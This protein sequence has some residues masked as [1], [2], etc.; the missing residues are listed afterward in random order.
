MNILKRLL[1]IPLVFLLFHTNSLFAQCNP[2]VTPPE[3]ECFSD[4]TISI[5]AFGDADVPLFELLVSVLD[6]CDGGD[7]QLG[8]SLDGAPVVYASSIPYDCDD[9]GVYSVEVFAVDAA[10]NESS[11]TMTLEIRDLVQP[12]AVCDDQV[13]IALNPDGIYELHSSDIDEGS[14]DYCSGETMEK[15][16]S[17]GNLGPAETLTLDCG[18]LGEHQVVLT[19]RDGEGNENV[20]WTQLTVSDPL[21]ACQSLLISGH[22]FFDADQD[23]SLDAGETGTG[24]WDVEL[25]NVNNNLTYSVA[26]DANG[27]YEFPLAIGPDAG[28]TQFVVRLPDVPGML[29]PCGTDYSF[30]VANGTGAITVDVPVTLNDQCPLMQVDIATDRLRFCDEGILYVNF[31]N[32]STEMIEDVYLE[33]TLDDALTYTGSN[34]PLSGSSNGVYT[35]NIGNLSSGVC[36]LMQ[37]YVDV[38]CE[39]PVFQTICVGAEIYP[40]VFCGE[41]DP[42]WSGASI[43]AEAECDGDQV[44]FRLINDGTGNMADQLNFRIVEDVVMYMQDTF[45]LPS[46]EEKL[47]QMAANGS[48][49]RIEAEQE[50]GHPGSYEP[51]AWVEG[52][53]GINTNGIINLFPINNTNSF[54]SKFCIETSASYDPNDKQGFPRGISEQGLIEP[55]QSL[56]YM[57]RFQNTGNDTAFQVVLVDTLAET[58]DWGS[59]RPGVSSHRYHFEATNEG[60]VKFIF[61]PIALPDSNVNEAA[62]HGF[63]RFHID[64]KPGLPL[65]TVIENRAGIYFDSNPVIITNR[66]KHTLG[67]D[68]I[69]T[70]NNNPMLPNLQ[71][72]VA[73]NPFTHVVY[74]NLG[75]LTVQQG[76]LQVF[77]ANGKKI[78]ALDFSGS[79]FELSGQGLAPGI[80]LF[81]LQADGQWLS[82]GKL[83]VK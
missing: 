69:V 74:F 25:T 56:D 35:F 2:D 48:T 64:Q 71:V 54:Q 19:V 27:Y 73:P 60:I 59:I 26:S 24:N 32:F 4:L 15:L 38:T 62:S 43:L 53:G 9:I 47:I 58:L 14:F 7:V 67:Q 66:T 16:I 30:T 83:M 50:P 52:C 21:D 34:V 45:L 8:Y 5:G 55:G 37:I 36:G 77:D 3:I 46:G 18:F 81:D 82:S 65:G 78:R 11:C 1:F 68:F 57:I 80:Y 70:A 49:W 23:C 42:L 79:T 22:V 33:V 12:V 20:C 39:E 41:P 40:N 44:S 29:M 63:V 75:E 31:C 76:T 13:N 17:L 6:E 28:Q 51:I 72:Q 61:D 10:S